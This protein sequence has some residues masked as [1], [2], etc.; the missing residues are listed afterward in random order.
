MAFGLSSACYNVVL[1]VVLLQRFIRVRAI[2]ISKTDLINRRYGCQYVEELERRR[3]SSHYII[4]FVGFIPICYVIN[5]DIVFI[6]LFIIYFLW[7]L[8]LVANNFS[9]SFSLFFFFF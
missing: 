8:A 6:Y 9:I 3:Y 7:F 4:K 1:F 2:Q 5:L